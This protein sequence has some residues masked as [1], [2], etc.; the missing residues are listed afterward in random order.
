MK[1]LFFWYRGE[2]KG[3]PECLVT[4]VTLDNRI[5]GFP[6]EGPPAAAVV[7]LRERGF[8]FAPKQSHSL[9][10]MQ[11]LLG[12]E[13]IPRFEIPKTCRTTVKIEELLIPLANPLGIRIV[14]SDPVYNLMQNYSLAP[15]G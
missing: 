12:N 10:A 13:A 7:Q 6:G 2:F 15:P 5:H 8:A 11:V 1:I 9:E 4:V 3:F 14:N